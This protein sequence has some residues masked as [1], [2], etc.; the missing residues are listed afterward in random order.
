M[1]T[2]FRGSSGSRGTGGFGVS[3]VGG[4]VHKSGTTANVPP[5]YKGVAQ[6][7]QGKINS[8][9]T[10]CNQTKG[11]ARYTR[12]TPTELNSFANWINKGAVIQNVSCAQIAK[13]AHSANKNFNTR[14]PTVAACKNVLAGKFGKPTIK[15]VCRNKSG[16]FMVATSATQKGRPFCFPC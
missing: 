8:F 10:L 6:T 5:K 16:G 1:A 2:S 13:W 4:S 3:S 14:N 15:A 7:F 12:P 9:K 11:A